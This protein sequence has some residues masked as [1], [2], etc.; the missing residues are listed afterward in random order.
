[1]HQEKSCTTTLNWLLDFGTTFIRK[2][3]LGYKRMP[4]LED[5]R[6]CLPYR[7]GW[8]LLLKSKSPDKVNSRVNK[9]LGNE[10]RDRS[11]VFEGYRFPYPSKIVN[12]V[13]VRIVVPSNEISRTLRGAEYQFA[14]WVY[15]LDHQPIARCH[16][17]CEPKEEQNKNGWVARQWTGRATIKTARA[18]FIELSGLVNLKQGTQGWYLEVILKEA[19][20]IYLTHGKQP[21]RYV[22]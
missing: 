9:S 11:K 4:C 13:R 20:T 6:V 1:M 2:Q 10:S 15:I 22:K 7:R 3:L 12:L 19:V 8:D 17:G 18:Q 16:R 21:R 5:N 14:L